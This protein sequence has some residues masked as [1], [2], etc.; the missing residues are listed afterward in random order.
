MSQARRPGAGHDEICWSD[1]GAAYTLSA[2]YRVPNGVLQREDSMNLRNVVLCSGFAALTLLL[3]VQSGCKGK[4]N[5]S[6]PDL[7]ATVRLSLN[8]SGVQG[9]Q[10]VTPNIRAGD[11]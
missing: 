1:G 7:L 6:Q 10:E 8:S 4:V 9:D 11:I 3:G 5:N 2:A